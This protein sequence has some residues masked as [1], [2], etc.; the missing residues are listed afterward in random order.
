MIFDLEGH[1]MGSHLLLDSTAK[2]E[3]QLVGL[4]SED[5]DVSVDTPGGHEAE[6][7]IFEIIALCDK[8]IHLVVDSQEGR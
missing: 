6:T 7:I 5:E 4:T 2:D 8:L 1:P 3:A